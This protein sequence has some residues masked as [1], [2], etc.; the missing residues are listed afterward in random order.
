[1]RLDVA[2]VEHERVVQLVALAHAL[3]VLLARLDAEALV[4]AL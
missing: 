4:D 3:D 2:G 1:M